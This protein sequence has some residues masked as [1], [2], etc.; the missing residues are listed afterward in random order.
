MAKNKNKQVLRQVSVSQPKN[1]KKQ[2]QLMQIRSSA[3]PASKSFRIVTKA[4]IISQNPK[5]MR[6]R[7]RELVVP[8]ILGSVA[9]G[10]ANTLSLN[11]GLAGVFPWLSNMALNWEQYRVHKLR[12]EY[13]PIAPSSTQGDILLSPDYD[14]TDSTPTTEQQASDNQDTVTDS[15]WQ[16]VTLDMNPESLMGGVSRKFTR[17]SAIAGDLKTFD[18]GKLYVI[19]NN[20]SGTPSFG[21]LFL[22]YDFEFFVPKSSPLD[23]AVS[24]G[25]SL[26]S[27]STAQSFT[28]NVAA[29]LQLTAVATDPLSF[30]SPVAGVY[31]PPAGCYRIEFAG[32]FSDTSSESFTPTV[33]FLKN[34]ASLVV[35]LKNLHSSSVGSNV[36]V[37]VFGV[38]P[39]NGSDTFQVQGTLNGAAGTLTLV[40]NASQL[41]VSLA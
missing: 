34:G 30:G 15:C 13:I 9:F 24:K 32:T 31:T 41:I 17:N 11:P 40:A 29:P 4:P 2:S 8:S 35:P 12:A 36:G 23:S 26:F 37:E 19:T 1:M 20:A 10:V 7:H 3:A 6:V 18:L 16:R 33:E 5:S 21:K 28:N 27:R 38:I 39:F 14:A 25:T 22:E